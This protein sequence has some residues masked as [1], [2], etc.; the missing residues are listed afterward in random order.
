MFLPLMASPLHRHQSSLQGFL[1]FSSP[2]I[3]EPH[4]LSRAV[5]IFNSLVSRYEPLQADH[6]RYGYI[7]LLRT[8]HEFVV[9]KDN[10]LKHLFLFIGRDLRQGQ[11]VSEPDFAKALSRFSDLNSWEGK[12][13]VELQQTLA[14]FS[15][16]LVDNFFLPRIEYCT[17]YKY[18]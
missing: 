11:D 2:T 7:T 13:S 17:L 16:Y 1:D 9:S 14:A 8:V 15:D 12:Q 18:H 5:E 4:Q 10:F 3:L 6:R